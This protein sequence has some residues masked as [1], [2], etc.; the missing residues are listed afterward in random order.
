MKKTLSLT[1]LVIALTIFVTICFL[2]SSIISAREISGSTGRTQSGSGIGI[3]LIPRRG[4]VLKGF[5]FY[6]LKPGQSRDN[7]IEV[8]NSSDYPVDIHIY[9][10]DAVSSESGA[11]AGNN[12]GEPLNNAGLWVKVEK[13]TDNL[14]PKGTRTYKIDFEVP[15]DTPP[16]DYLAFVFV[17]PAQSEQHENKHSEN[18]NTNRTSVALK[19]V[20]RF[21]VVLWARVPG[22]HTRSLE[23]SE[24]KKLITGGRLFLTFDAKNTGNLFM[25][26]VINWQL[27]DSKDEVIIEDN[28]SNLGYLLPNCTSRITV[29]L[30][31][32]RPIARG[33]YTLKV[34]MN[35]SLSDYETHNEYK[36]KLP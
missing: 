19:V 27:L 34:R 25:K 24:I 21:G 17:Q 7:R 33:E 13:E 30:I 6:D 9:P 10:G 18:N 32:N 16:G 22:E 28:S 31:S 36:V 1:A 12:L 20:Q 5:F 11:L 14:P 4:E 26:P 15:E 35:D 8:I 23:Y 3:R 2:Q 29:P